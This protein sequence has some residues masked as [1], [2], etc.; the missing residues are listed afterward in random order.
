[1]SQCLSRMRFTV[2]NPRSHVKQKAILKIFE[3]NA[4]RWLNGQSPLAFNPTYECICS[5][6]GVL[7]QRD[8]NMANHFTADEFLEKFGK[9]DDVITFHNRK[10]RKLP[11]T[12]FVAEKESQAI[13]CLVWD[14]DLASSSTETVYGCI[15]MKTNY[16]FV[17]AMNRWKNAAVLI[18]DRPEKVEMTVAEIEEK[19]GV[20]NLKI[21][22]G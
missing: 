6:N 1:M 19:L 8:S 14:D 20:K 18:E 7:T 22:K 10:Y 2:E 13:R 5:E 16:P 11:A 17:T 12:P 4:H 21:K 15:P 9:D 3:S